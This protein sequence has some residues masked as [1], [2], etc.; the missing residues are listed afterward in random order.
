MAVIKYGSETWLLEK[1]MNLELRSLKC[2]LENIIE[3]KS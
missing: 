2:G 3:D 1:E